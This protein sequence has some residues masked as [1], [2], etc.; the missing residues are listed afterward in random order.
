MM[1]EG[2][3][4]ELHRLGP[5]PL[6]TRGLRLGRW[7]LTRYSTG[8]TELYDLARDPME[9]DNLSRVKRYADVLAD[10]KA[11]YGQ[12]RNCAG[13]QCRV[14]LP[15]RWRLS[16]VEERRLTEHEIRS[17]NLFFGN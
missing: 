10:M 4:A 6:N 15:P 11:L 17:T 14:L 16:P 1:P 12:Y 8:E 3:Y 9:L 2:R 13:D 7:K 5:S